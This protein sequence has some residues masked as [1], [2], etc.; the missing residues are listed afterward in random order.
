MTFTCPKCGSDRFGSSNCLG[1]GPMVRH[2]H[3]RGCDFTWPQGDDDRYIDGVRELPI[4]VRLLEGT[5][6][7]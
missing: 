2:C 5:E 7:P 3:G 4:T 6:E 1:P